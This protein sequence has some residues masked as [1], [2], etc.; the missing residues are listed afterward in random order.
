M[1]SK[2]FVKRCSITC[3]RCLEV[4]LFIHNIRTYFRIIRANF[5]SRFGMAF[6]RATQALRARVK[7]DGFE[8]S[9]IEIKAA[10]LKPFL[11]ELQ[12]IPI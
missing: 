8:S 2:I 5:Y 11:Q 12:T 1:L 3:E 6:R 4:V 10:D 7:H 9:L